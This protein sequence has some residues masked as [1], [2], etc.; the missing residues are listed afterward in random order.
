[1]LE[2]DRTFNPSRETL[3]LLGRVAKLGPHSLELARNIFVRLGRPGRKALYGMSNLARRY[4]PGPRRPCRLPAELDRPREEC[5]CTVPPLDQ[6]KFRLG[7]ASSCGGPAGP[8]Q[9]RYRH[10]N[11][12]VLS[13]L[14]VASCL[15]DRCLDLRFRSLDGFFDT[16]SVVV[17]REES[18][19][20]A[21]LPRGV[22]HAVI[23]H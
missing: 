13:T 4:A 12:G 11:G 20:Q 3:R 6:A 23:E 10:V 18:V 19:R 17:V 21:R 9:S 14:E 1:M 5:S 22:A 16:G 2:S 8:P 15:C 7:W